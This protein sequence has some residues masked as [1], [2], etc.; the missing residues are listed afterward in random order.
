[1][2]FGNL[3][4][5]LHAKPAGRVREG[6]CSVKG[7]SFL[8]QNPDWLKTQE[9][10]GLMEQ[11]HHLCSTLDSKMDMTDG[12]HMEGM[13]MK[14]GNK[15]TTDNDFSAG[16]SDE[17]HQHLTINE[18]S[19]SRSIRERSRPRL[20]STRSFPPYSQCIGGLGE[21]GELDNVLNSELSITHHPPF[22]HDGMTNQDGNELEHGTERKEYLL[23]MRCA[24]DEVKAKWRTRR[25]QRLGGSYEVVPDRWEST[26]PNG[27]RR[28]ED[29]KERGE[30]TNS[31]WKYYRGTSASLEMENKKEEDEE[32]ERAPFSGGEGKNEER[33][34]TP[35]DREAEELKASPTAHQWSSPHPILSRLLHSSTSSSCSSI[36]LS[37]AES[38]EVFSEGEDAG[39]KRRTL[40]KCRSWK[41]YLTM[42]HWSLQRQSSWVQLAG[43]QGTC[44]AVHPPTTVIKSAHESNH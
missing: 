7:E 22:R 35:E 14:T 15:Q 27:R 13:K 25:R 23:N 9:H 38:D 33:V 20:Q 17:A 43:H 16:L 8:S 10:A 18:G 41:T 42:M 40:R 21:D 29:D 6:C 11:I 5:S 36:S 1:M 4:T 34:E 32:M 12:N 39:S 44:P 31:E 19:S 24:R 3:K 2:S 30:G 26:R 37:S 28:V